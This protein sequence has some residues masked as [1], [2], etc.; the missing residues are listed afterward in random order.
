MRAADAF[1]L[2][3]RREGCPNVVLEALACGLP[4][5]ATRVGAVPEVVPSERY[6][7]VVPAD[8]AAAL[9]AALER[10][11]AT[12]WDRDAIAAWGRSRSW[13]R[14]AEELGEIFEGVAADAAAG[15]GTRA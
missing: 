2:A 6:G 3:S 9:A 7:V 14:V 1:C 5:V 12:E 8:D 13:G 15:T 4:V 10:A 11:L